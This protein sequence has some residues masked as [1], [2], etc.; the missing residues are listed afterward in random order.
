MILG[1]CPVHRNLSNCVSS[2]RCSRRRIML[3]QVCLLRSNLTSDSFQRFRCQLSEQSQSP[4]HHIH[5]FPLFP[6]A[7]KP[8]APRSAARY[9]GC[10]TFD[11]LTP[12]K[13]LDPRVL[14]QCFRSSNNWLAVT[15][16]TT[17][18]GQPSSIPWRN[19]DEKSGYVWHK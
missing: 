8:T 9:I 10:A 11:C 2:Y 16:N 3:S 19:S 7:R 18:L 4:F 14:Q 15:L 1:R 6:A 13:G 12:K 5:L 17:A